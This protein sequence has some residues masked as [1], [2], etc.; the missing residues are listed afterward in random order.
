MTTT[1]PESSTPDGDSAAVA[2]ANAGARAKVLAWARRSIDLIPTS[3]L[4][5]A[6]GAALL[7]TTALFGGL[8]AAAVDPLPELAAGD[9][10]SGSDLE[11]TVVGVELRSDR[12]NAYVYPDE[13][14]NERVLVV[15]VDVV[16]TFPTPRM[17]VSGGK[18]PPVIDGIRVDGIDEPA[19]VSRADDGLGSPMLQPD[20][21][22]RLLVAWIVGPD[23]F[24]DGEEITLTL[25]DS[26]HYVGKSVMRG[27][28]WDEVRIGATVTTTIQEVTTP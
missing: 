15:T 22:A 13:E 21:P 2:A 23:D 24:H 5:T 4:L 8:Q 9:T 12:G 14:K 6:G 26:T 16:N 18:N 19:S 1:P 20:V 28:Y 3:W 10:F 11:M 17:S 27:D 25:P 7:A